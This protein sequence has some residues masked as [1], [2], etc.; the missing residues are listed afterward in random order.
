VQQA[1]IFINARTTDTD[2]KKRLGKHARVVGGASGP[3]LE[4]ENLAGNWADAERD[5]R[6]D[7]GVP[8]VAA[9]ALHIHI[10]V[11]KDLSLACQ[12]AR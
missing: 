10:Y 1:L 9:A 12:V 7:E 3:K 4:G 6:R 8:A 2:K 5:A 11:M